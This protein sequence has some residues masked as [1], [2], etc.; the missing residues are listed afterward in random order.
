MN[1]FRKHRIGAFV[2]WLCVAVQPAAASHALPGALALLLHGGDHLH[3]VAV[4]ADDGHRDLVLSHDHGEH[5]S[6]RTA[7]SQCTLGP[8][9]E[10]DHVLHMT[11]SEDATARRIGVDPSPP[12]VLSVAIARTPDLRIAGCAGPEI[13]ARG[14]DSLG[15]VVLRL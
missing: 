5:A 14:A 6:H 15:T 10:N 7:A 12:L 2:V 3:A 9:S 1:G 4:V 13:R 11:D 8:F